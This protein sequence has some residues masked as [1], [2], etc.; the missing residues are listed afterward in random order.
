MSQSPGHRPGRRAFGVAYHFS[1]RTYLFVM[2]SLVKNG[3]SAVYHNSNLQEPNAGEDIRQIAV[4]I[5]T[6]F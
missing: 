1:R 2:G 3:Y 6:A 4:G 5:H